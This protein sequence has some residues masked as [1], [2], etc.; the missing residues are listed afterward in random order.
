MSD[1]ETYED[2]SGL[3]DLFY[4]VTL[5]DAS[6]GAALTAAQAPT[7]TMM[8]CRLG[9][10]TPLAPTASQTLTF[11]SAGR[12]TG[13]HDDADV[14]AAI[15]TVAIGQRFDRVLQVGTLATRRMAT[16]RRVAILDAA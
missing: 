8:L 11:Q 1:T 2:I 5:T 3:D 13:L 6:T 10:T 15:G 12:W 9:T 16:C 4:D 7:V 14:L